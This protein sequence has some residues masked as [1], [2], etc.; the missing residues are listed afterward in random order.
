MINNAPATIIHRGGPS[1]AIG[2]ET[3]VFEAPATSAGIIANDVLYQVV[4]TLSN[5]TISY[6]VTVFDPLDIDTACSSITVSA[7]SGPGIINGL[8]F[9]IVSGERSGGKIY[10]EAPTP[11]RYVSLLGSA[12]LYMYYSG[13]WWWI[14]GILGQNSGVASVEDDSV[15]P[16]DITRSWRQPTQSGSWVN[17]QSISLSGSNC[18]DALIDNGPPGNPENSSGSDDDEDWLLPVIIVVVILVVIVIVAILV[19]KMRSFRRSTNSGQGAV[20]RVT[21]TTDLS[22]VHR[23]ANPTLSATNPDYEEPHRGPSMMPN[24]TGPTMSTADTRA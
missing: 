19:V 11:D 23:A 17:D 9:T 16:Q 13:N 14:G 22:Q 15:R 10:Y 12:R 18:T 7:P 3:L 21:G 8:E 24:T 1:P 6:N 5:Q 20:D 4:A 2:D